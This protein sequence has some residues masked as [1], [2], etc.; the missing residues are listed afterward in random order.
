MSENNPI[1][2]HTPRN[3]VVFDWDV[4]RLRDVVFGVP[5][6]DANWSGCCEQW[7]KPDAIKWLQERVKIKLP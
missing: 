7:M 6:T 3:N 4:R 2:K 5:S 1:L